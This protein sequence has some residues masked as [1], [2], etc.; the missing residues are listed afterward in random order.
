MPSL[1]R[2]PSTRRVGEEP[3]GAVVLGKVSR[4]TLARKQRVKWRRN[5]VALATIALGKPVRS[6]APP[7][8]AGTIS[9][10]TV[11]SDPTIMQ[12]Q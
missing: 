1:S 11:V 8:V 10:K 12:I 3:P 4:S 6:Y 7:A 5:H 2:G 9:H